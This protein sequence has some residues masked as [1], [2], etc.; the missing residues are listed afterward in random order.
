MSYGISTRTGAWNRGEASAGSVSP[1]RVGFPEAVRK[2]YPRGV[3]VSCPS[4]YAPNL[5]QITEDGRRA[6]AK[7]RELPD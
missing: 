3:S 5:N 6:D 2:V 7:L 4:G 1:E